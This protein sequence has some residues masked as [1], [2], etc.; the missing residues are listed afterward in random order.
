M[1]EIFQDKAAHLTGPVTDGSADSNVLLFSCGTTHGANALPNS[2]AGRYVTLQVYGTATKS[3]WF[4]ISKNSAAEVDRTI[5]AAADGAGDPKLGKRL[6]VGE[7]FSFQLPDRLETET[8][9]FVRE[10]DD[11]TTT[12][13]M[14][15]SSH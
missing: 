7:V 6:Q 8:L 2:F 1:S 9:Y 3:V 5:A 11:A 4:A 13:E 14:L 10:T 12:V 15:C